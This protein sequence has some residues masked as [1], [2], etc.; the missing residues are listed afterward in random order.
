MWALNL[1]RSP[2]NGEFWG[3]ADPFPQGA[4]EAGGALMT[5]AVRTSGVSD[6]IELH[7]G[8]HSTRRAT[9]KGSWGNGS[10]RHG[11]ESSE[12]K[13]LCRQLLGIGRLAYPMHMKATTCVLLGRKRHGCPVVIQR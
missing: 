8:K 11:C 9:I 10:S 6:S 7:N 13:V 2:E 4:G 3:R 12:V 5:S 1:K